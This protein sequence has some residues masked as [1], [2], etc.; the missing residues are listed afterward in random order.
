MLRKAL[1]LGTLA[2]VVGATACTGSLW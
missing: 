1:R 2:W